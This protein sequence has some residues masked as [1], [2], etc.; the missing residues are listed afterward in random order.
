MVYY[1]WAALNLGAPDRTVGFVV[2]TGNF[3]NV[4]AGYVASRMGLPVAKFVVGSNTNDILTRFMNTGRMEMT[5]VTATLSPS[6]DIQISSN[7]ER[8]LF[9]SYKRDGK[10]VA[11]AMDTFRAKRAVDFGKGRW[12]GIRKLF[13]GLPLIAGIKVLVAHMHKDESLARIMPPLSDFP[14]PAALKARFDAI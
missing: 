11:K 12:K 10:A 3:G 4:F 9:E 14:D 13:D 8:L 1:F 6:M 2:P 7:F 5:E